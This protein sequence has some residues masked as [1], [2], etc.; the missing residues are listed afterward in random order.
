MEE[1]SDYPFES[2][3]FE[4]L[5]YKLHFLDEGSRHGPVIVL[6]HGVPTWSYIYRKIIPI[7]VSSGYRVI[8]PDMIGFGKSQKP[9]KKKDHTYTL[10]FESL[11]GLIQHLKLNNFI[12]YGQDWGANFALH[13]SVFYPTK[14]IGTVVSNGMVPSGHEPL[15]FSL[16][17]WAFFAKYSP[18]LPIGFLVNLGCK[19]KLSK[20][21]QAAYQRPFTK[22]NSLAGARVLPGWIPT[23]SKNL[24]AI[25]G[26]NIWSK[27]GKMD[28][29][30][31]TLF[32]DGD[33]FTRGAEK[34]IIRNIP[35]SKN[36][37]HKIISGGHFLQEDSAKEIANFLKD[38]AQSLFQP[39]L[40]NDS[41][42]PN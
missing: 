23:N 21:E 2:H 41:K 42:K 33:P 37:K 5:R 40:P 14:I 31:A 8:C 6:L 11:S 1:L 15:S 39:Y 20:A 9:Q 7:L 4:I 35:G 38:F 34:Y 22:K 13:L 32:S 26:Q 12:I 10:H 36:Q 28:I 25:R 3:Y 30:V 17:A 24:H 18:F 29:P 16:R 19:R 27:L